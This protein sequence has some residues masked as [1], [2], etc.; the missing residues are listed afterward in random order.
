[1][2]TVNLWI[3]QSVGNI[4]TTFSR[5]TLFHV[6]NIYAISDLKQLSLPN[7]MASGTVYGLAGQN[8]SRRPVPQYVGSFSHARQILQYLNIFR[9][10]LLHEASPFNYFALSNVT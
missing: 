6:I 9:N 5:R 4:L 1:M 10:R 2:N 3:A 8:I 7:G